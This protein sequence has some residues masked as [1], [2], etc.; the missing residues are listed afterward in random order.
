MYEK[1]NLIFFVILILSIY[2]Q[3]RPTC[4]VIIV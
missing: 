4:I 1:T 2:G 3:T